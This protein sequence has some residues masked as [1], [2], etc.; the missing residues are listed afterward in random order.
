VETK[1][2]KVF[3]HKLIALFLSVLMALSCFTGALTAFAASDSSS[4]NYHDGNL[5]YN[6]M[7]WAE[8]TDEQTAEALL[9]YADLYLGDIITSLLGSDHI[10]FSQNIVIDTIKIDAYLDSIDGLFDTVR[11]VQTILSKYGNVVGGDVKNIDLTPISSLSYAT[12]GDYVVSKC[13]KSYRQVYSAKELLMALLVRMLLV[14]SLR[15][16]LILVHFLKVFLRMTFMVFFKVHSI[17]G[18]DMKMM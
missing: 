5:A 9:D 10:S 4:K 6:F 17:C 13:N 7:A 14:S 12:S 15:V 8:T 2:S 3:T 18:T 16:N 11:Q 1:K